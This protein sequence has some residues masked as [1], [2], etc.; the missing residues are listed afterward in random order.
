MQRST[1]YPF[2]AADVGFH[3]G[4]QIVSRRFL[5]A[6]AA[7][8][9]NLLQMPV[10]LCRRSLGRLAQHR[11]RTRWH[12]HSRI[13]MAF[14]DL[15]IDAVL[16]VCTVGGERGDGTVDLIKQGADL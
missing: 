7:T 3:Q 4:T 9:R 11:I 1:D 6:N 10:S 14:G 13:G 5:P 8:L 16:V 15:A 2:P 12:N